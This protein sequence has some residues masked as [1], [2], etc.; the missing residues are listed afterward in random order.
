MQ[1]EMISEIESN[2]P[3]YAV[4]VQDMD[5]WVVRTNSNQ[6]IIDWLGPYLH[7]NYE[8]VGLAENYLDGRREVRWGE[9]ARNRTPVADVYLAV[10]RRR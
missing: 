4:L 1:K 3:E 2:R 10:Y 5:S 9:E 8:K 6:M 7:S